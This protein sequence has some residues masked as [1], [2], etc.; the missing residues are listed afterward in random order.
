ML[1]FDD[2]ENARKV[3]VFALRLHPALLD[4]NGAGLENVR[5]FLATRAT[6]HHAAWE[7]LVDGAGHAALL[8]MNT[9]GV[10]ALRVGVDMAGD[11]VGAEDV[12]REGVELGRGVAEEVGEGDGG[13]R[14]G[15]GVVC[16]VRENHCHS[17][18]STGRI[19]LQLSKCSSC[20][21]GD[22]GGR[23]ELTRA[24]WGAAWTGA[25][26]VTVPP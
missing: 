2:G 23:P 4:I 21:G 26:P 1:L 15:V 9:R 14:V 6:A 10:Q 7:Q 24:I 20:R 5:G 16:R 8:E 12:A 11:G 19:E 3:E 17:S 25:A 18:S 22:V 13:K